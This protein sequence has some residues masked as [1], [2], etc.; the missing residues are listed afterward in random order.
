MLDMVLHLNNI[1]RFSTGHLSGNGSRC[2]VPGPSVGEESW[3]GST[4]E[5]EASVGAGRAGWAG[6]MGG[7]EP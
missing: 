2:P 1:F 4:T 5:S 6:S 3:N 7:L